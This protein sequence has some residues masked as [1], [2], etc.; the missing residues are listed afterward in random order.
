[1]KRAISPQSFNHPRRQEPVKIIQEE[2]NE[3][4]PDQSTKLEVRDQNL[5]GKGTNDIMGNSVDNIT[6]DNN[7]LEGGA[8]A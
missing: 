4:L 8:N 3:N 2:Q 1:M 7:S 6:A 5:S